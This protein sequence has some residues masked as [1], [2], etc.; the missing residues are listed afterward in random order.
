VVTDAVEKVSSALPL[1]VDPLLGARPVDKPTN[2]F[3]AGLVDYALHYLSQTQAH[4][5]AGHTVQAVPGT[6]FAFPGP[7]MPT[8]AEIKLCNL[9]GKVNLLVW[10]ILSGRPVV[11]CLAGLAGG[12]SCTDE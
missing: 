9:G 6:V 2:T 7:T 5:L 1:T 10:C 8:P 4:K 3:D 12:M 11:S